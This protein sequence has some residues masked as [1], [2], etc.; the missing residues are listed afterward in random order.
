[1]PNVT[2]IQNPNITKER[3]FSD[4]SLHELYEIILSKIFTSQV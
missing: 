2:L 3:Q 4:Q 1:M